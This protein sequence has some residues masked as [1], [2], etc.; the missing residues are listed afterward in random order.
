MKNTTKHL[1]FILPLLALILLQNCKSYQ[2]PASTEEL[3]KEVTENNFEVPE[4]WEAS[5]DTASVSQN[6]YKNFKDVKLEKL[7]EEAVDSTN[8][9]IVY[10]LAL[11]E[12]NKALRDLA[13]SGKRVQ[14]GYGADYAGLSA[15]GGSNNYGA[16]AGGGIAWE[17]DLW[18]RIET[19]ILAADEN[20]KASIYNYSFTRQ[21]IAATT[22]KL[23]F[24]IG[25]LNQSIEVG[26]DFIEVNER[27]K[28]ILSIREE[29]GVIDMKEVYLIG[30]Q[31]ASIN[32]LIQDYNDEIQTTTRQLEVVL[33]RYPQNKLKVDWSARP[34]DHID[35]IGNPFQLIERRPDL[36]RDE[37]VVR[38]KFYLTEEAKLLKYPNLV[39]S[40]DI[41]FSTVSDLI[42]GTGGSFFGPIYS[43][44]AIDAQI[45]SATA[46]QRQALMSYGLSMLN[47]FNEVETAL[48]SEAFLNEQQ[49]FVIQAIAESKHA[50]EL[51]V[52]QYKVG[53]VS[54]FEVL[55]TQMQWLIKELDLININ[56]EL[57]QRRVDLY[58]A[59]G[60][61]IN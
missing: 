14:I 39:L 2:D 27:I 50:Y 30:A 7:V 31:T 45:E 36:K 18:G 46:E 38:S 29:V 10:Q 47:A 57:Y 17:A 42:F 6:W 48:S 40:A 49:K 44:G 52:E 25:T 53:K 51:M 37:S 26:E 8:L 19:G 55:Q 59:L 20:L 56:G 11:I 22:S 35:A 60:G 3:V 61:D 5:D 16:L 23:Y 13:Q 4:F 12:Q 9:S 54:L 15:T 32:N 41:G 33:G 24:K 1:R 21:S 58:L 34:L 28:E 43:G